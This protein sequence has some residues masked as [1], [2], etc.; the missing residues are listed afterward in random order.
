M[1]ESHVPCKLDKAHFYLIVTWL[2]SKS[3]GWKLQFPRPPGIRSPPLRMPALWLCHTPT[4]FLGLASVSCLLA[5]ILCPSPTGRT[6]R[7]RC[8]MEVHATCVSCWGS[9]DCLHVEQDLCSKKISA[10]QVFCL[11]NLCEWKGQ[12]RLVWCSWTLSCWYLW[13]W[14]HPLCSNSCSTE[15]KSSLSSSFSKAS[16]FLSYLVGGSVG[17]KQQNQTWEIIRFQTG[18]PS[19]LAVWLR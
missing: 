15:W 7:V 8:T 17:S 18:P 13:L 11:D 14:V 12:Y 9:C 2:Q 16:L 4:L 1:A 3:T 5:L 19:Y 10:P 6:Y